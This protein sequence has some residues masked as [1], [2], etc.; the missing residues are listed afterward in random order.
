MAASNEDTDR[1]AHDQYETLVSLTL[2]PSEWLGYLGLRNALQVRF[3][4]SW[5]SVWKWTISTYNL[6]PRDAHIFKLCASGD[7]T[8]IRGL[9]LEG[10]A[11]VQD[12]DQFGHTLL[13]YAVTHVNPELYRF[14]VNEG[15]EEILPSISPVV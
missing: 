6:V 14:L 1:G 12:V 7:L 10:K 13:W 9:I 8:S 11:S 4:Q 2:C 15:A 3:I 5:T